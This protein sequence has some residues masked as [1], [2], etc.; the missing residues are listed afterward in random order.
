MS[1]FLQLAFVLAAIIFSAK[2]AGYLSTRIG[3]PS[4]FGE[5]VVG[6]LLGPSLLD[7]LHLPFLT[8]THLAEV[9]HELAEIGVLLLMFLAGMEL[10]LQDLARNVRVSAFGGVLGVLVPVGAGAL[11]GYL[12]GLDTSHSLFLGLTMGATSVSISAQT[13]MELKVLRSRV[14][15]GLLGAAVFDDIIVILL[16]SIFTAV[17]VEGSVSLFGILLIIARM[18]LFIGLAV[19][20]GR[21]VLPRLVRITAKLPVSQGLLSLALV[22]M[23]LFGI[24]AELIGGMA[25]ITGAFVA[26][27]M[28][29][30]TPEKQRIEAGAIALSYSLFVPVFFVDIGLRVNVRGLTT[31]TLWIMLAI[32]V[33][34]ILGKIVGSGAGSLLGGFRLRE[35]LQL[36]I[37]MVSRGEVGLIVAAVGLSAGLLDETIFTAIVGMV[38]LTTLVTP[39]MLRASFKGDPALH[40]A[41]EETQT[42]HSH[43]VKPEV[44]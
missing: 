23:L 29:A 17:F 3:Q 7:L 21:W 33:V 2:L 18:V 39:P 26:G 5:L 30:R 32:T 41:K 31:E 36:G 28:F 8:N 42:T 34:G 6:L 12:F 16:L 22:I 43:P 10:H 24:A 13:L 11:A 35:A 27:L 20:F 37:G 40:P 44:E 9:I 25:A 15:L 14:G 19:A 38:L 4:V 1:S